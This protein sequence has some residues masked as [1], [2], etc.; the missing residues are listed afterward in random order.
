MS[1]TNA[2]ILQL[3]NST[4][5]A[6]TTNSKMPLGVTTVIYPYDI[7]NCY[8]TYTVSSSSADTLVIN[9]PGTYNFTYS[10]SV[11]ATDA[12]NVV[13][14]ILVNGTTKYSVTAQAAA[15]GTVNLTIPYEIYVPSNCQ[16]A[17]SNVPAYIQVQNTGV[18][19]TSGTSNLIVSKE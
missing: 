6:V 7:S 19:L 2:R 12:G 14:G 18:A 17:P 4:I 10:A 1:M 16:S 8:P 13:L 9:N 3:T 15:G 11:V 5:G